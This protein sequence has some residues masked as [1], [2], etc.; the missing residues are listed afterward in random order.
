MR[1]LE[2]ASKDERP[3]LF[4]MSMDLPA[5]ELVSMGKLIERDFDVVDTTSARSASDK[6]QALIYAVFQL[7]SDSLTEQGAT[8]LLELI[9]NDMPAQWESYLQEAKAQVSASDFAQ[10]GR[11]QHAMLVFWLGRVAYLLTTSAGLGYITKD[12]ALRRLQPLIFAI[13]PLVHD[14]Q[15]FADLFVEG[16]KLNGSN[17]LG[18]KFL[19]S[20]SQ[21]LLKEQRSPW[22]LQPWP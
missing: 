12:E 18:R 13:K 7:K 14:W 5:S 3:A 6:N 19:S 22:L 4:L 15:Q 17:A 1:E 9:Q 11:E 10:A 8:N 21:A 16:D 2:S 20:A